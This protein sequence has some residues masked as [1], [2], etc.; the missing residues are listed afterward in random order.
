MPISR[1]S[2]A[3]KQLFPLLLMHKLAHCPLP[4][5]V[6]NFPKF[7]KPLNIIF[8][9]IVSPSKERFSAQLYHEVKLAD[10]QSQ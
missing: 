9:L 7:C 5:E 6:N 1:V 3:L 8:H 2:V 10:L 4:T